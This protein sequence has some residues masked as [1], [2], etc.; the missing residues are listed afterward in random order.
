MEIRTMR[1]S[2]QITISG[3]V[4]CLTTNEPVSFQSFLDL[5][6]QALYQAKNNGRNQVCVI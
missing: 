5:A 6:D 1:G 4:A 3:G 2:V